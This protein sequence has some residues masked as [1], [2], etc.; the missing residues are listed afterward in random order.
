MCKLSRANPRA[1]GNPSF[2][3][4]SSV[5]AHT[6]VS[7]Q[8]EGAI[9]D[10]RDPVSTKKPYDC[11]PFIHAQDYYFYSSVFVTFMTVVIFSLCVLVLIG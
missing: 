11:A 4:D 9:N 6:L 1:Y 10:Y 3:D 2:R 5:L 8:T 7:I